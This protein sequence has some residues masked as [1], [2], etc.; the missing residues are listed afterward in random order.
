M[1]YVSKDQLKQ[2]EYLIHQSIQ[3][4]HVL[5][6]NEAIRRVLWTGA[7]VSEEEAYSVEH[8]IERLIL[9]PTLAEKR[10][11]LDG[12]DPTTYELVVKTYLSIVE[13]NLLENAEV[14][15]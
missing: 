13:N 11:Y 4:N 7:S 1:I 2:V 3:G 15:H 12:L 6:D 9:Q 5:F 8:L 10:A 14:R